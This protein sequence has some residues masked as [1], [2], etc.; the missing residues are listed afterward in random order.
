MKRGMEISLEVLATT[1]NEAAAAVLVRALDSPHESLREGALRGLLARRSPW[2]LRE[3]MARWHLFSPRFREIVIEHRG[4]L[5]GAI[6][7]AILSQDKQLCANG[8]DAAQC[9]G[10]YD[11]IPALVNVAESGAAESGN[12][13][14]ADMAAQTLLQ[15]AQM[16]HDE[17][18][19]PRD[20]RQ[21][22]NPHL[23]R[24][25]VVATLELATQRFQQHRRKEILTAFLILTG[26][27]NATL[28]RV[29]R[30]PLDRTH[31]EI[32]DLLTL[33]P[34]PAIVR[35]ALSFLDDSRAPKAAI[36]VLAHRDDDEFLHY[37]LRKIG[38]EP[39]SAARVNL[40]R[41]TKIHWLQHDATRLVAFDEAAQHA[42]V[43][44][45]VC[46]G[47]PRPD[48]F[49]VLKLVLLR[50]KPAGRRAAVA[51]LADF[52]GV[53]ANRLIM[54][55]VRDKDI[56]V[57][58]GALSQ[59]R[60]RGLPGAMAMLI[61]ALDSRHELVQETAREC[62]HE[63]T[64][65]RY[66]SAFHSMNEQVRGSTGALVRRVDRQTPQLLAEEMQAASRGRRLR[67]IEVA[68]ALD[69]VAEMEPQFHELLKDD[70]HMVRMEAAGAL[71]ECSTE[72][73]RLAL[74]NAL[75]DRSVAVQNAAERALGA[76]VTARPRRPRGIDVSA[77][78]LPENGASAG[79]GPW[80][81]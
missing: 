63:F 57:Q 21:R 12:R 76:M 19:R 13:E 54:Q 81:W 53:E 7:D 24:T 62:L 28:R 3:L 38:Y 70:D 47:L 44:I 32:I 31:T 23:Y 34:R 51:A 20:W 75:L 50:G 5:T 41:L 43:Q 74:R 65:H 40:K 36:N 48:K 64:F 66:L 17:L 33:S 46:S 8:C 67:A 15:L 71:A 25:H 9:T 72:R 80:R 68:Q 26:R 30:D 73:T 2:G 42:A 55:A 61:D 10:E 35:L 29:L 4:R 60:S 22:R 78:N 45:A 79:G 77:I 58:A 39:S 14:H 6:R 18:S 56:R 59:L 27:E 69:M 11:L 1:R 37:L 52:Q 49:Q 16:L